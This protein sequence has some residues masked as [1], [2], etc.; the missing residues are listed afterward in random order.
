[1]LL[2]G[3]TVAAE[4]CGKLKWEIE[5]LRNSPLSPSEGGTLL[6]P[7]TYNLPPKLGIILIGEHKPAH[8]YVELKQKRCAEIGIESEVFAYPEEVSE[9][10]ILEKITEV[11]N[12]S[13][14]SGLIIQLP[15]PPHIS[16]SKVIEQIDPKKDVD[17]FHP[18]NV[19]KL[20]LGL[21]TL[22][23]ATPAGVMR[24]L[25]YYDIDVAGKHVVVLGRSNIVGK[26]MALMLINSGATV[27]SCNSKTQN[28]RE[29]CYAADILISA[30]GRPGSM[31]REFVKPGAVVIDIGQTYLE[32]GLK[33]DVDFDDVQQIVSA[34]TPTPGG[35]GPMTIAM[36]LSNTVQAWRES[37]HP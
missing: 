8:R 28:I 21:P 9:E 19:G 17:G 23:C 4:I 32:D 26:P 37:T 22:P 14:I 27:T 16:R 25:Q 31:N 24:M 13:S 11:N 3:T 30:T 10:E 33:G 12:D 36:L 1:M 2:S 7:A 6:S 15:L 20:F 18:V 5:E 34:I 35:V 29:I